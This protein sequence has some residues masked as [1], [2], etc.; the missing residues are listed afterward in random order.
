MK[1]QVYR[2]SFR[3]CRNLNYGVDIHGG[4]RGREWKMTVD[5]TP[6]EVMQFLRPA[7]Y[8]ARKM[9]SAEAEKYLRNLRDNWWRW[10]QRRNAEVAS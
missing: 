9:N 10:Q 3:L 7:R 4:S 6:F 1:I 2:D 5:G 8:A